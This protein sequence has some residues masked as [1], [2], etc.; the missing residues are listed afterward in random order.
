VFS[1]LFRCWLRRVPGRAF[2]SDKFGE[3]AEFATQYFG[4]D[5][6]LPM[7]SGAEAVETAIKI[8]RKYAYDVRGLPADSAIIIVAQ[9]NFH[10]RTTTIVSF[11]TDPTARDGFGPYTPGFLSVEYGNLA[12]LKSVFEGEYGPR[13]AGFLVEPIQGEAGVKI[14]PPGYLAA[15]RDLCAQHKALF[16]TD[17]IQSGL[18]R[19]GQ[20][21]A[22]CCDCGACQH[23]GGNKS[24]TPGAPFACKCK[25][26][27]KP[28]LLILGKALSGGI[29]PISAVLGSHEVIRVLT[30]GTHGSTFGGNAIAAAIGIEA[31]K[32]LEEENLVANSFNMG[33]RFR[34]N[35]EPLRKLPYVRD[36]RG[37]GLFNAIEV[38]PDATRSAWEI[39]LALAKRGILCK[40]THDHIIR[41]TP[42]L[43]I[44]AVQID[45]AS[46]IIL[47]V[48][49]NVHQLKDSDLIDDS[50]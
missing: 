8:T 17:E 43:C 18:G 12:E 9:E 21:L 7:N 5:R 45:R 13:I 26:D 20:L 49:T 22:Y 30:S 36:V 3:F 29:Y 25:A 24:G 32:V 1:C 27:K 19:A 28:D 33:E 14:P 23:G 2:Y 15:A 41:L 44:T 6:I 42:P 48:F 37:R 40:P 4:F 34:R 47:D 10:G 35:L 39:C 11:S 50:H 31:L 16:I 46:H 38:V